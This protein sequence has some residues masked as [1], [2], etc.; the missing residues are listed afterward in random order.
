MTK[1]F[2][3]QKLKSSFMPSRQWGPRDPITHYY[4]LARREESSQRNPRSGA[5]GWRLGQLSGATTFFNISSTVGKL[6]FDPKV[7]E[8]KKRAYSDDWLWTNHRRTMIATKLQELVKQR[9]SRSLEWP[10]SLSHRKCL[11]VNEIDDRNKAELTVSQN[12]DEITI[13]CP[14]KL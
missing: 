2:S 5:S 12:M 6:S 4:W 11:K 7:G 1:N 3:F 8:E 10:R 14:D 13:D 9:R